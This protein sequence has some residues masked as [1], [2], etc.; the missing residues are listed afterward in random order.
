MLFKTPMDQHTMLNL[1]VENSWFKVATAFS[2]AKSRLLKVAKG[3]L[4]TINVA[5]HY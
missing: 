3:Y 1:K 4:N 2:K 5:K